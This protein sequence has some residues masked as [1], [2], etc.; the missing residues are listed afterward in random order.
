MGKIVTIYCEGKKGSH[1]YDILEKVVGDIAMIKPIG[2]KKGA[3]AIIEFNESG[4]VKS[5]FYCM[6]RDRDFDCPVPEKEQ[7]TFDN[8]K[9]Y[10]SYRT[11]IENYLFDDELFFNFIKANNIGIKYSITKI[12]DV[13]SL[14]IESAKLIKDYQSVRHTLGKIRFPNS[15]DTT[16][17]KSGSGHL[18][19]ELDLDSCKTNGWKLI[20]DVV[21]KNNIEWTKV[22]FESELE[23]FLDKFN[24]KFFEDLEFLIHFQGKDFAKAL[25]N[26]LANFPLA[27]YY[28]F[29]KLHFDYKKYGDLVEL[30]K[31][32]ESEK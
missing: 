27:S 20:N 28:K 26:K 1:D 5:D 10:F 22:K 21:T 7:L 18:P 32:I 25:I 31:K 13:R 19:T 14:F 17:L 8:N 11:T 3:N 29:S 12:D 16:W 30:R 4:T 23:S 9:T 2:G 6:F 15:F 24:D